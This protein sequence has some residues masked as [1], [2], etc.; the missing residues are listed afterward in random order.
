MKKAMFERPSR[1]PRGINMVPLI[2]IVF[3]L[4]VFFMVTSTVRVI[5][6]VDQ[7]LPEAGS[8]AGGDAPERVLVLYGDGRIEVEGEPVSPD[9]LAAALAALAGEGVEEI[10]VKADGD[11]RASQLRTVMESARAAGIQGVALATRPETSR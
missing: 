3:L 6:P 8:G 9:G 5:D 1:H 11:A 10:L 2:N 4:L 7:L